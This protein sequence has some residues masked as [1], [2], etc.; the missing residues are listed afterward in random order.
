MRRNL[1]L[2]LLITI[3]ALGLEL[4]HR[5]PD[6]LLEKVPVTLQVITPANLQE[7]D[8]VHLY[9]R[10]MSQSFYQEI[11]FEYAEGTYRCI[12]PP[13]FLEGPEIQYY[14]TASFDTLGYAASPANADPSKEPHSVELLPFDAFSHRSKDAYDDSVIEDITVIPWVHSSGRPSRFPVRYIPQPGAAFKEA[15][16]IIISGTS[17]AGVTDLLDA[18]L[19]TSRTT[20]AH[21]VSSLKFGIYTAK[22]TRE[23][24]K[25]VVSLEG[26]Y[27]HRSE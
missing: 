3:P 13:A 22:P 15:G 12:I 4:Y 8:F 5:A 10:N 17:E 26:I 16:Y 7:P 9:V 18:M 27:L 2:F 20:G 25:G 23:E 24:Y 1:F 21:A 11:P 14:I 19:Q 6:Q